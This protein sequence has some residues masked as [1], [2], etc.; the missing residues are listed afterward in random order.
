MDKIKEWFGSL[1]NWRNLIAILVLAFMLIG[2]VQTV[3][4]LP[5]RVSNVETNQAYNTE[6]L[7]ALIRVQCRKDFETT[8][9]AGVDCKSFL[10]RQ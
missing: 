7:K 5:A 10:D 8:T 3:Q 2:W 1:D 9:L 4:A 6:L